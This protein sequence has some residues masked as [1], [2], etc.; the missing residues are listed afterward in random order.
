MTLY[1]FDHHE[2]LRALADKTNRWI[3]F[4]LEVEA[5]DLKRKVENIKTA[6]Q[7]RA[8]LLRKEITI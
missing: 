8:E 2:Y 6:Q 7:V 1:A 5:P 4:C 3:A